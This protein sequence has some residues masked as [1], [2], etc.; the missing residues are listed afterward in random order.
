[1]ATRL[2]RERIRE[3]DVDELVGPDAGDEGRELASFW[4]KQLQNIKDDTRNKRWQKR[5]YAI[6]RRYRDERTRSV[7]DGS[8]RY[9]VLWSN[10]EILTPAIYGKC[11][12]PMAERRFRDKDPVGR[13]AAQILERALRNEIEICGFNEAMEQAVG[14][15]LLAGRGTLWVRYEPEIG[16][17][18]SLVSEGQ[19]DTDGNDGEH[20]DD[21]ED[22]SP[23]AVKLRETGDRIT[24][25][26]TPV[27]FI[28]W[29]DFFIIPFNARTWKEVT[30]VGKRVYMTR[31]QMV[32]RFGK[33]IGKAVPLQK[34]DR[35]Q[36]DGA[37]KE[38]PDDK[39]EVFEI[40]SMVDKAVFWI[41]EGYDF[42]CDRKDDPLN[43]EKFFPCPR[44]IFS[45][46]TNGTLVPVPDYMEYQDQAA[47]VDELTQRVYMLVKACKVAGV[48]NAAAKDIARLFDESV[49]NQL[50]P[51]DDWAAFAEKG[52]VAGNI[53]FMPLKEIIGVI[54]ELQQMKEKQ[55]VELDRLTGINDVRRGT[56][57]PRETLGG[58]RLKTNNTGTRLQRRQNEVARLARDT[59]R[60]M[61]DIM[62]Q[63]FSPQSLIEVSGALYEEGLGPDDMP[64]LTAL[65]P[66][67]PAP[68]M[69]GHNGG[70]PMG[71]PPMPPPGAP[72]MAGGAPP[73]PMPMAGP[74]GP[75]PPPM[76]PMGAANPPP[77]MGG[78]VIPF[79][80][81]PPPPMAGGPQMPPGP[82]MLPPPPPPNPEMLA[83]MEA[84]QRIGKAIALIRNERLRGFRVD[85]E[86]DSTVYGD[87]AQEKADRTQ[88]L[89]TVTQYIQQTM[90][91]TSQLPEIA[92]LLGKFLQFGVRGFRVGRD[93]E[94]AIEDFCDEAPK[95]AKQHQEQMMQK[96]DP[97]QI[98]AEATMLKA[99]A[100]AQ[101]LQD[102]SANEKAKMA[103]DAQ[104][105]QQEAMA[106]QQQDA[107][108]VERQRIENQGEAANAQADLQ[109]KSMDMRMMEMQ[110]SL[111]REAQARDLDYQ[112]RVQE[113]KLEFQ[114]ETQ[115][116]KL[117]IEQMRVDREAKKPDPA[118]PVKKE[119]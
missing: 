53:S 3:P 20:D 48:Y 7:E 34:D 69:M 19:L 18:V 103:A 67:P 97:R 37:Q 13:G 42:L 23:D 33:T 110:A 96:Q 21:D 107:A 16:P 52:G 35:D 55:I 90:A 119:G 115:A 10:I 68:P 46:Q 87:S 93:L 36:R 111:E 25:E 27:D 1:M 74:G 79:P 49:E 32:Q 66:P 85:I 75:P 114:K 100:T 118:P 84:I 2:P 113:M 41:A 59:V 38:A 5:A 65:N 39:G 112:R 57:D 54:N 15:Y 43:L 61:A 116:M 86:V 9:N 105:A 108:E 102:K 88:F 73:P 98:T 70:P 44:P 47:Q 28:N 63:H 99:K 76:P 109:G 117:E 8:R 50:I 80:A 83:K 81:S 22:M 89:Q 101:S 60:I 71:A 56:T 77:A 82:G 92:P 12:T 72:P 62:A 6:E 30:A 31:D 17:G 26:S 95:L 11:P 94:S 45:N 91:I 14:D 51:V 78:N 40:W 24:R 58:Q 106:Q 4:H 64:D 29:E 104:A